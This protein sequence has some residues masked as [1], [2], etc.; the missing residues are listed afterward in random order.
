MDMPLDD[1]IGFPAI[2]E[3]ALG[4]APKGGCCGWMHASNPVRCP[5]NGDKMYQVITLT[6]VY[7]VTKHTMP[8]SK[9]LV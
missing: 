5:S 6:S 1:S 3:K 2:S 4:Q 9:E 8:W 7:A